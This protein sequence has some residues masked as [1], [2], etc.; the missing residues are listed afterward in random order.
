MSKFNKIYVSNFVYLFNF[1]KVKIIMHFTMLLY[2]LFINLLILY[3]LTSNLLKNFYLYIFFKYCQNV[4]CLSKYITSVKMYY[5]CQNTIHP[6]KCNLSVILQYVYK[7]NY[8]Y[9]N[10]N[11]AW[12]LKYST[13]Q[14]S[15]S[16]E[17]IVKE[18]KIRKI[19]VINSMI[20]Y[21]NMGSVLFNIAIRCSDM[22]SSLF[23]LLSESVDV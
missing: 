19:K 15:I 2:K 22:S 13:I 23:W 3:K 11:S 17:S 6:S 4:L 18:K 21:P 1:K 9:V 14:F 5:V 20:R 8:S 7:N 12:V 10:L 16:R